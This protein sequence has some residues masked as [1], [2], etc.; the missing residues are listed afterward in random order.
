MLM[1]GMDTL[2]KLHEIKLRLLDISYWYQ[3]Q[4]KTFPFINMFIIFE[5]NG[6]GHPTACIYHFVG[7][8]LYGEK[9]QHVILL[10][11]W[12]GTVY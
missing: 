7:D 6:L 3:N 11:S 12:I 5:K 8:G 1:L 4:L 2:Y 9:G 10:P